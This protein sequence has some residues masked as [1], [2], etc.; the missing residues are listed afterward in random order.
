[1]IIV[2]HINWFFFVGF[3]YSFHFLGGAEIEVTD[4]NKEEYVM[5]VE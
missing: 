4:E 3:F 2:Q 1:M 5:Y